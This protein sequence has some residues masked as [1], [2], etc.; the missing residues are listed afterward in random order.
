MALALVLAVAVP[1][2]TALVAFRWWLDARPKTQATDV[3]ERL[4]ALE[5]WRVRSEMGKLR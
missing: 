3:T 1:C 5:S 4:A 2:A